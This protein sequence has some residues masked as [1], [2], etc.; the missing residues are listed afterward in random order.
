ME[1]SLTHDE[2]N[3]LQIKQKE[4]FNS[5][6]TLNIDFRKSTLIKIKKIIEENEEQILKVL[7]EDLGKNEIEAF[8]SEINY[9]IE[10]ID[11]L[12]ENI[13]KWSKD[14]KVKNSLINFP[15]KSYYK[16]VPNGVCLIISSWNYP[17]GLLL[18]PIVGAIAAGNCVIG[19]PSEHAP[20]TSKLIK[21]LINNNFNEEYIKIIE[22]KGE[23]TNVLIN[24]NINQVFFTGGTEVGRIINQEASKYLIKVNLELGGKN[25]CFVDDDI[26]LDV[27]VKRIIWGK[28]F[29]SGQTCIAPDYILVNENIKDIFINK[30]IEI[31]KEFYDNNKFKII[32]KKHFD[33]LINIIKKE[34]VIYGGN[35]SEDNLEIEATLCSTINYK[36]EIFGPIL[37]IISYNNLNKEINKI[38][39]PLN[40]YLFS[41]NKEKQRLIIENTNSGNIVINGTIHGIVNH[42]L[43]FGGVGESGIGTY[44]GFASFETFSRKKGIMVKSF[45][46]DNNKIYP[47]YNIP[48][49]ILKK[50]IKVLK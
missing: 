30:S 34:E 32:N 17:F 29:N 20:K 14:K 7:L 47:P 46:F 6:K 21:D 19:K 25:P 2:I 27:T 50:I 35:Y 12:L 39:N 45:L 5:G 44:H 48:L 4:F 22:L 42:H 40:I 23:E 36:D 10:E 15:S 13:D 41:K 49:K 26:D 31:I 33:R 38:Q 28:F 9:V 37:P 24:E 1:S 43:P 8:T 11:I 16:Y 3:I 18:T